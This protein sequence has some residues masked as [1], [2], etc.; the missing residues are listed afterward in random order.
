MDVD[1]NGPPPLSPRDPEDC[2]HVY[3]LAKDVQNRSGIEFG[4]E[5]SEDSLFREFFG[6]GVPVAII[7]WNWLA[8]MD[9]IPPGIIFI[10]M[11]WT[12]LFMKCYPTEGPA[13]ALAGGSKGKIDPKTL[14]KYVHPLIYAISSLEPYVVRICVLT[15]LLLN[16]I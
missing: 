15:Y 4:S 11:L 1:E 16:S 5:K 8:R 2:A 14:R 12:L 3:R 6:C 9:L 10:H 13:T 7:T